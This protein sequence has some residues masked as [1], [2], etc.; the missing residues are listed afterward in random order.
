MVIGDGI[1]TPA[2]SGNHTFF[3]CASIFRV[4]STR[5]FTF[6]IQTWLICITV[7]QVNKLMML[8]SLHLLLQF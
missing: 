5:K 8:L 7:L 1:L 4:L 6:F 2:I 3:I